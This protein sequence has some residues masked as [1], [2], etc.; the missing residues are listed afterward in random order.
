MA[1]IKDEHYSSLFHGVSDV[2]RCAYPQCHAIA[3]YTDAYHLNYSR[4]VLVLYLE[5][6]CLKKGEGMFLDGC[7]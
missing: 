7:F 2:K 5:R 1:P 6:L 4:N 3:F